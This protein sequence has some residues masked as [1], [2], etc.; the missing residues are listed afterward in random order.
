[1][2]GRPWL[3][4]R[5]GVQ[6]LQLESHRYGSNIIIHERDALATS[7]SMVVVA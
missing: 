5:P 2:L 4:M 6:K 7:V 1:M 3:L